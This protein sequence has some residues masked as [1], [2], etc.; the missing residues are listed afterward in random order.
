[1]QTT[2]IGVIVGRFQAHV[3]HDAHVSLILHVAERHKK[4][5][6]LLGQPRTLGTKKN[7][8]DFTARKL[9]ILKKFPDVN[10]LPITDMK[11]DDDWSRVLDQ[12]VREVYPIGDVTLYGSRDSFIPHYRG[13]FPVQELEATTFVNATDLR[14]SCGREVRGS[15]D[16]RAGVIYASQNRYPH[17]HPT[18]DVAVL[19]FR[20]GAYEA[21]LARKPDE[22]NWRFIG[23]FVDPRDQSLEAAGRREVMEEADV[24]V[25]G[26]EYVGSFRVADWRY[27][28]EQDGILTTLFVATFQFGSVRPKDDVAELRWVSVDLA[29]GAFGVV[30]EPEHR[31]MA[32][33]VVAFLRSKGAV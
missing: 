1:M 20:A 19:R 15:S 5:L 13:T 30:L 9:M 28:G 26:L 23:G 31:D 18:V 32:D 4:V 2:P 16:F 8:L 22:R 17:V 6:V 21:L 12:R 27:A 7:P 14:E 10:V 11:S 3:L 24:S 33:A 29:A 25:D